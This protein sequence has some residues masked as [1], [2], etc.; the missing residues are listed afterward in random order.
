MGIYSKI[1]KYLKTQKD[2]RNLVPEKDKARAAAEISQK[3]KNQQGCES[4]TTT[5]SKLINDWMQTQGP[6]LI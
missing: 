6:H 3:F 2:A 1:Y 5:T 4:H